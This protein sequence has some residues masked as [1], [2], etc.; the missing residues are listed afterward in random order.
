M[1]GAA[2][3]VR[4]FPSAKA[5]VDAFGLVM[6]RFPIFLRAA[7]GWVVIQTLTWLV[8]F[9]G[10]SVLV[11]GDEMFA[12]WFAGL[13]PSVQNLM[14]AVLPALVS[15]IA[16]GAIAVTW[17]RFAILGEEP[18]GLVPLHGWRT[19][20]YLGRMLMMF[21]VL[22]ALMVLLV[23]L[24]MMIAGS[25]SGNPTL[26]FAIQ[27]VPLGIIGL[28]MFILL[29]TGL[30][31]PAAAVDDR[32]WTLEHSWHQTQGNGWRLFGGMLLVALPFYVLNTALSVI[33]GSADTQGNL[34]VLHLAT[35]VSH[36]VAALGTAVAAG[37]YSNAF[38][39]F[40]AL[41]AKDRPPASHFS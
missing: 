10:F 34:T 39:F 41:E 13:S 36:V 2:E 35:S 19:T 38:A 22:I 33:I 18:R 25:L 15:L 4:P 20:R 7:A 27:V 5:A 12:L 21:G 17:H 23:P 32:K 26:S 11:Q 40:A 14:V 28:A 31:F 37:Y 1:S 16:A 9:W 6:G 30:A 29:R 24:L 3:A 8:N